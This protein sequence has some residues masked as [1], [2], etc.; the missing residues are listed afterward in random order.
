[1]KKKNYKLDYV[2]KMIDE[3]DDGIW[4][5]RETADKIASAIRKA[6][7]FHLPR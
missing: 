1:M 4:T 7:Y 5:G 6:R 2:E 3:N